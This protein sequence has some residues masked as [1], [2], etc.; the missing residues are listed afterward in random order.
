MSV[1]ADPPGIIQRLEAAFGRA[2]AA[3]HG[4]LGVLRRTL[5]QFTQARGPQAAAAL[6]YYSLFSLFPLAVLLITVMG[7]FVEPAQVE[8]FISLLADRMLP[9]AQGVEEMV[10]DALASIFAGRGQVTVI[11]L[12]AL[13]WA[14]SGVFTNL[15]FNVD[16][17]WSQ[18]GRPSPVTARLVG[19]LMVVIVYIG[20]ILLLMTSATLGVISMLPVALM[21]WLGFSGQ[22]IGDWTVAVTP[23]VVSG[24]V[25]FGLYKWVPHGQVPWQ[26]AFWSALFAAVGAYLLNLS[27]TWYLGSGLARYEYLYGPLTAIIVLMVWFYLTVVVILL[28]AHFGAALTWRRQGGAGAGSVGDRPERE[29]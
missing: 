3:S 29:A 19:L 20:L 26:V 7:W 16:L 11:S 5:E 6:S 14:A 21:R 18:N 23:L 9:D 10:M 2:D 8:A 15:T 25:F 27:F 13:L 12:I 28:G 1:N 22:I 24:L 17:A 4:W